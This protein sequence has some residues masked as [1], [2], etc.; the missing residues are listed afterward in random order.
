MKCKRC[1][2]TTTTSNTGLCHKCYGL[3]INKE[4]DHGNRHLH[5]AKRADT[6]ARR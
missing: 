4:E 1:G 3:N 5:E 6:K 2:K